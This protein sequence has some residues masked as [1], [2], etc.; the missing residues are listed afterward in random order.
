MYRF[1]S[2][3]IIYALVIPAFCIVIPDMFH[4]GKTGLSLLGYLWNHLLT[5]RYAFPVFLFLYIFLL[6]T[7]LKL[8]VPTII[9]PL[10]S[11]VFGAVSCDLL[12]GRGTPLVPEDFRNIISWIVTVAKGYKI[13]KPDNIWTVVII[14][15]ILWFI[16]LFARIRISSVNKWIRLLL[17][18]IGIGSL[19][20]CFFYC[21]SIL[22]DPDILAQMGRTDTA[23][24]ADAFEKNGYFPEFLAQMFL[25]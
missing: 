11:M 15:V 7:S 18:L 25:N 22:S 9:L 1:V 16:T 10:I 21:T 2:W 4:S 20:A 8:S 19:A 14:L 23:T 24:I 12:A 17:A 5:Y 13:A 6:L 3:S